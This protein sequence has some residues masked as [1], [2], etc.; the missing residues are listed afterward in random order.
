ML[1]IFCLLV[2]FLLVGICQAS[3][4]PQN[5]SAKKPPLPPKNKNGASS[6]N[7]T[8]EGLKNI[9]IKISF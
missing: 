5:Y 3:M 8:A 2:A 1:K 6:S 9:F 7:P 4:V